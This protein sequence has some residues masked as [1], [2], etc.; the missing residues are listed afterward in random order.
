MQILLISMKVFLKINFLVFIRNR[1]EAENNTFLKPTTGNS[2][3]GNGIF[4]ASLE[5]KI[6]PVSFG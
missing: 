1:N 2:F 6:M 3:F 4:I 5:T